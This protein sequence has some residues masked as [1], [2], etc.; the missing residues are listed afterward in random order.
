MLSPLFN[1]IFC[2]HSTESVKYFIVALFNAASVVVFKTPFSFMLSFK[3]IFAAVSKLIIV[4]TGK[5]SPIFWIEKSCTP[6]AGFAVIFNWYSPLPVFTLSKLNC[7]G[8]L[9]CAVEKS[10]RKIKFT[11]SSSLYFIIF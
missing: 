8:C 3:N 10:D 11:K 6:A 7:T 5:S 1:C 9:S 4:F 2:S